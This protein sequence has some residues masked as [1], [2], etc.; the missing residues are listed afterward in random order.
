MLIHLIFLF[1]LD[2]HISH[3]E[4]TVVLSLIVSTFAIHISVFNIVMCT[5]NEFDPILL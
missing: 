1:F 3:S 4:T 2:S 5:Q